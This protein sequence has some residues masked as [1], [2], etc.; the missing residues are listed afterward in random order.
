[1]ASK[2]LESIA[3]DNGIFTTPHFAT[4]L[5]DIDS[6]KNLQLE[7]TM[8]FYDDCLNNE[9][10]LMSFTL[11]QNLQSLKS[12][13]P[14]DNEKQCRIAELKYN[15]PQKVEAMRAHILE[16][17]K[18]IQECCASIYER[19]KRVTDYFNNIKQYLIDKQD[20]NST[21]CIKHIGYNID[22]VIFN[23]LYHL[24]ADA[25]CS[26]FQL[27][28]YDGKFRDG[29]YHCLQYLEY[30]FWFNDF[31]KQYPNATEIELEQL[32]RTNIL[33]IITGRHNAKIDVQGQAYKCS[34]YLE[35]DAM[36]RL[37]IE[38]DVPWNISNA[39]KKEFTIDT[40]KHS[41]FS[42]DERYSV[43]LNAN[44]MTYYYFIYEKP[45]MTIELMLQNEDLF[46]SCWKQCGSGSDIFFECK[47]NTSHIDK[48]KK[49]L[50]KR[51]SEINKK[52]SPALGEAYTIKIEKVGDD[53]KYYIP[54][55][56]EIV[57]RP[58]F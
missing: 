3:F 53:N 40:K 34:A 15:L 55:N 51:I 58:N 13:P 52:V 12:L 11:G 25:L 39:S 24:L 14:S 32:R 20:I 36:L 47:R 17:I 35:E 54:I 10:V 38:E 4:E 18:Y 2:L 33:D 57:T 19:R 37:F 8:K 46:R 30:R 28:Q 1:M 5:G 41:L 48:F 45:D 22:D 26:R 44:Q 43:N 27:N 6:I 9:Q 49:D 56:K 7:K 42:L 16:Q 50:I 29:M 31:S 21:G 23:D